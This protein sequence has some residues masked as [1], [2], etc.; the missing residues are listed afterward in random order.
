MHMRTKPILLVFLA[1]FLLW[2]CEREALQP[3]LPS[4]N[5][6]E[7][8]VTLDGIPWVSVRVVQ[9]SVPDSVFTGIFHTRSTVFVRNLG[10]N[11]IDSLCF[12]LDLFDNPARMYN[13]LALRVDG[14]QKGLEPDV[15][16]EV[17][18][19][20]ALNS[21]LVREGQLELELLQVSGYPT[22]GLAGIY[23]GD[24]VAYDAEDSLRRV[25]QCNGYVSA[26]GRLR[27]RL[28]G[29]EHPSVVQGLVRRSDSLFSGEMLDSLNRSLSPVLS[30][31]TLPL[32]VDSLG[33]LLAEL[34]VLVTTNPEQI[35]RLSVSLL[36]QP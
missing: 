9:E 7:Q 34:R 33:R 10:S 29:E 14:C 15:L 21:L 20:E 28:S 22:H 25:G 18:G 30:P 8:D 19:F 6:V 12:L 3:N 4:P 36:K 11:P 16:R 32:R 17:G 23:R 31:D 35:A 26:D 27:L 13:Q 5:M 2:N 24:F 1:A